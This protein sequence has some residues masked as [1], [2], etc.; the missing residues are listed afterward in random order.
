MT[1]MLAREIAQLCQNFGIGVFEPV[2]PQTAADRTIFVG[3]LPA[4]K[5][6]A[7]WIVE[8]PSP[9]PH[10]YID[11]EYTVLDFWVRSPN[12]DRAHFILESVYASFNRRHH[13]STANWFVHFSRALGSYVDVDRDE[14]HGKI[15]RLSI[16]FICRN[17]NNLS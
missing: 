10:N 3:E 8:S 16:Q 4:D 7:L 14:E 5:V 12:T 11:T 6:E 17:L 9:P 13:Y 2:L 1:Q 15:F